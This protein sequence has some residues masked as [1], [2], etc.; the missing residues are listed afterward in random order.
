MAS[1]APASRNRV[2][3]ARLSGRTTRMAGS[4]V[5]LTNAASAEA[6]AWTACCA[7]H[8]GGNTTATTSVSGRVWRESAAMK[9]QLESNRMAAFNHA[10]HRQALLRL[11]CTMPAN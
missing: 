3:P 4:A 2:N 8:Q 1:H 11:S 6:A 9:I 5:V 7:L 10:G